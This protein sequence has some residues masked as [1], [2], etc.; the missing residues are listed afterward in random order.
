[1]RV[2]AVLASGTLPRDAVVPFYE[3]SGYQITSQTS[4]FPFLRSPFLRVCLSPSSFLLFGGNTL[5]KLAQIRS[6]VVA[7]ISYIQ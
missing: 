7:P 4:R 3:L 1:M 6:G 5:E 2:K